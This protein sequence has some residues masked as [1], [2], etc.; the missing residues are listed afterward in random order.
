MINVK[1]ILKTFSIAIIYLYS[2][3][4]FSQGSIS[5]KVINTDHSSLFKNI[6]FKSVYSSQS[7]INVELKKS[8]KTLHNDG[9]LIAS[10]D[11]IKRDTSSCIAY[12]TIGSK[13]KWA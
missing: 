3:F 2:N 1:Q 6:N 4:C 5:L 13:F 11:S 8:I 12:L 10:F 9:Y 7:E